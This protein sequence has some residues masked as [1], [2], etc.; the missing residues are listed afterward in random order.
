MGGGASKKVAYAADAL[1]AALVPEGGYADFDALYGPDP[2]PLTLGRGRLGSPITTCV[3][4]SDGARAA[5]KTLGGAGASLPELQ[6]LVAVYD[7]LKRDRYARHVPVLDACLSPETRTLRV[8]TAIAE[9]GALLPHCAAAAPWTEERLRLL[10]RRV[11]ATLAAA[12]GAG[13]VHRQVRAENVL[14]RTGGLED[15]LLGGWSLARPTARA[16][17]EAGDGAFVDRQRRPR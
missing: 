12:H 10:L 2:D 17:G 4:R 9:G 1:D 3:R 5:V 6:R 8:A 7:A 13:L 14:S 15:P 16:D 11:L